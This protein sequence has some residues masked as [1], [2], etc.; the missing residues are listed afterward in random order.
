[1]QNGLPRFQNN[2][3]DA[4][5]DA[6]FVEIV[7]RHLHFD[8]IAGGE[9]HKSFAHFAG[10]RG[11]DLMFVVKFNLKHRAGQDSQNLSFDFYVFFHFFR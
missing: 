1:M 8:A 11:K 10:D 5:D 4:P 9:A 3:T 7:G 2:S 6:S